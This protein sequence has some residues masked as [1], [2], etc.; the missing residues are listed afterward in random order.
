MTKSIPEATMLLP[1][2]CAFTLDASK[3]VLTHARSMFA[4]AALVPHSHPRG[5][6]LWAVEG[7]LRVTSAQA[8]WVVPSTHS[9][10]IPGGVSHQVSCETAA[11]TCNLFIDPSYPVRKHEQQGAMLSMSPLMREIVLR[12]T[13][14]P[15][16][17][18][19]QST[20]RLGL[21]AI[22]ELEHL[23]AFEVRLPSGN[24]P[25]LVKLISYMVQHPNQAPSLVTLANQV[26]AS[27]RTIER[28]FKAETGMT[29]RQ[30]RSRFRLM[31][32]LELLSKG[33]SSTA[34]AHSLGYKSVSSFV[35]VFRQEF[36]RTPQSFINKR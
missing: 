28:L 25:R 12:L 4:E 23:Q 20:Q 8:V 35:K 26:G 3:P 30:W 31:N 33:E 36:G 21:V 24:D 1:S 22:D 17:M 7:V 34:V 15:Q 2:E 13:Q 27:V 5:Q 18:D 19:Q 29:F 9:V 11:T 16:L 10:W 6:L 32:S 14:E